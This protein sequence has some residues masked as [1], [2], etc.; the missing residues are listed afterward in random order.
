MGRKQTYEELEQ[1]IEVLERE[2]AGCRMSEEVFHESEEKYRSMLAAMDDMIYICTSDYRVKYMNSTMIRR[3][4]YDA[5]GEFCYK[6]LHDRSEICPWCVNEI[7][8]QGKS[9]KMEVLSPKDGRT[10]HF[11]NVPIRHADGSISKMAVVRDISELIQ[12]KTTLQGIVDESPVG[13]SLY[14]STG[15]CVMA[16]DSLCTMIGATIEEVLEQN[17]HNIE[18]WKQCGLFEKAQ[19]TVKE[20]C[21]EDLELSI[22]STFGKEISLNCHLVPFQM[23][24][25]I[26]LFLM[27]ADV[28]ERKKAEKEKEHLESRLFQTQKMEIIGNMADEMAREFNEILSPIIEYAETTIDKLPET[29]TAADGLIK[30]LKSASRAKVLIQQILT[31]GSRTDLKKEQIKVQSVVREVLTFLRESIPENIEI[32][33]KIDDDCRPIL[34]SPV[35]IYQIVTDLCINAYHVMEKK[36]G[37]ITVGLSEVAI[38]FNDQMQVAPLDLNPK[39]YIILSVSDTGSGLEEESISKTFDSCLTAKGS[40]L[41]LAVVH[42]LVKFCDGDIKINRELGAGNTID[43]YL[44]GLSNSELKSEA[45]S[46]PRNQNGTGRTPSAEKEM[47][48][49]RKA[50][51]ILKELG[52]R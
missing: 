41:S 25:E 40:G 37:C 35:H 22:T 21:R 49:N 12:L 14:D 1:K 38:D 9:C 13:I 5:T 46:S 36:G 20:N 27:A 34:A 6:A 3:T 17:W 10:L 52:L 43:I 24:N 15:Q 48:I 4:G 33:Q 19:R 31:I 23:N 39:Y 26:Y 29:S 8:Q 2:I 7:I 42:M 30:V 32:R 51:M 44:S 28:T 47:E 50:K 45:V 11:S 16:N 18:S